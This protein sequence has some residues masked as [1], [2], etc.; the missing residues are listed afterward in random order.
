MQEEKSGTG[1]NVISLPQG[2]GAISG[3]GESFSPNLFTGTGNF[4]VPIAVPPGR[5]GMQPSLSLGYSTGNG[6]SCFG[7]GWNMSLPQISRKTNLGIPK[8]DDLLDVFVLSGAED[9]IPVESNQVTDELTGVITT[10]ISYR[11]RTEGL[12]A[13]IDH[14]KST[15][16]ENY[17]R[18]KT[19]DG[20]VTYYGKSHGENTRTAVL[21]DPEN[22]KRIACWKIATTIDPFG[23]SVEYYYEQDL[24]TTPY[25]SN[26]LYLVKIEFNNY[27]Y[28][29]ERRFL[30]SIEFLYEQRVDAF[31]N[32]RHAFNT[33]TSKRCNEIRT[34]SHPLDED[35]PEGYPL[36]NNNNNIHIRSYLLNYQDTIGILYSNGI[37]ILRSVSTEGYHLDEVESLPPV[38]FTYTEFEISSRD[39]IPITGRHLPNLHLNHPELDLIDLD[40]N[41]LPDFVQMSAG[42]P[43]RVWKNKGNGEFS[44]ASL[45]DKSPLGL[46]LADPG[47]QLM[48]ADGDGRID[49]VINRD[50]FAGYYSLNHDGEWDK[51]SFRK[52]KTRPPLNL[53][54]AQVQFMDLSGDGR[55]DILVNGSQ[56]V[57]YFQNPA[58]S[59]NENERGG[60]REH[61]TAIGWSE[62]KRV[63]KRGLDDFPNVNFADPRIRTGDFTGDGMQDVVQI[64]NGS[65]MYWPNKGYGNFDKKRTMRNSPKFGY[66]YNPSQLL[67]A[68]IN[69]DGVTDLVYVENNKITV[70]INQSGNAWSEPIIIKGTP[71]FSNRDS[72][73]MVDLMG[74]GTAGI[75]WSYDQ[76]LSDERYYYLDINAGLKPYIMTEMKNNLG[77]VTKVEYKSSVYY[78]L[79]DRYG[80]KNAI[81]TAADYTGNVGNWKTKLPFP[82]QVV[83]RV[84]VIDTISKGKLTT[85]YF[86]HHGYWDGGEREYRGFARVDQFDTETFD[87]YH[88]DNL[89]LNE[90]FSGVSETN[91][92]PPLMVKNWYHLGPVGSEYGNWKELDFSEEYWQEDQ[93]MLSRPAEMREMIGGLSRRA[94]RDAFR[95]LRGAELRTELYSMDGSI[96]QN[97]PFT[98]SETQTG[99]RLIDSPNTNEVINTLATT[100]NSNHIFFSYGIASRSTQWERGAEPMTSFSF[101]EDYDHYG[102]AL[103]QI[104]IAVPRGKNPLTGDA[105]PSAGS[106]YDD[107][108]GYYATVNESTYIYVNTPSQYMVNR[109][110]KMQSKEATNNGSLSVFELKTLLITGTSVSLRLLALSYNYYDGVAFSNLPFGNIGVYGIPTR[111]IALAITPDELLN[112]YGTDIPPY[113]TNG[114]PDWSNFPPDFVASLQNAKAGYTYHNGG[115]EGF[116]EG[117]YVEGSRTKF[118]FQVNPIGAVGLPL[119]VRDVFDK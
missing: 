71:R 35:M 64:Q 76:G 31:S 11:P 110:S 21:T 22:N 77:A 74:T 3:M 45:M 5:N 48:D 108:I 67:V 107:G 68:D 55:T 98:V 41:G 44:R 32:F 8:Y 12:F 34:Y 42:Q 101:T 14:L 25:F 38:E 97:R 10:I 40:G 39:I 15:N 59:K 65:V 53:Q 9:L 100:R 89:V 88:E 49:L 93:N 118:D 66:Q 56:L 69:G 85:R 106:H 46:S 57:C 52:Y 24:Q 33:R 83:S 87:R 99:L 113:Y 60:L 82:V 29:N 30:H 109:V 58:L 7:L 63:N 61:N 105:L 47:V 92:M 102:Q 84:E 80:K 73:R 17:W 112:I 111:S 94:R 51:D 20:M 86:Y 19:K 27:T 91:Y 90:D 37:S 114:V 4:T 78:Y 75:L 116:V 43:I 70:W 28:N 103:K 117:W 26:Q 23:N 104:N 36:N 13:K 62:V 6:N 18:V 1:Q 95:T 50:N 72:V 79:L 54:S 115:P 16:G 81:D 2:G 119:A 96:R